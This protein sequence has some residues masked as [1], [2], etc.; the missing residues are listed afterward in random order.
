[1]VIIIKSPKKKILIAEK[2]SMISDFSPCVHWIA[3]SNGHQNIIE[4]D[5]FFTMGVNNH[6]LTLNI[7]LSF[8]KGKKVIR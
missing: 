8:S 6:H 2:F 3:F 7:E 4:K 5:K 1:M